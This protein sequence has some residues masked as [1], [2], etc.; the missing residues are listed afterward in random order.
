VL[1]CGPTETIT[2]GRWCPLR[3]LKGNAV[4]SAAVPATVGG[5]PGL[6][7]APLRATLGR[8]EARQRPASQETCHRVVLP[9]TGHCPWVRLL[10][11]G[12]TLIGVGRAESRMLTPSY[13]SCGFPRGVALPP[14]LPLV[15][16]STMTVGEVLP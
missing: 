8:P 7:H 1:P 3:G 16:Q 10:R 6:H 11:S 4:H 2:G 14:R 9:G 13:R 12:D 15:H 5:E